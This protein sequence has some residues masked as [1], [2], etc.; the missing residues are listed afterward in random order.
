MFAQYEGFG[1]YIDSPEWQ[2]YVAGLLPRIRANDRT[3][4][5]ADVQAAIQWFKDY[6]MNEQFAKEYSAEM[7]QW[8][9]IYSGDKP[10]PSVSPVPY[11]PIPVPE[12]VS[13]GPDGKPVMIDTFLGLSMWSWWVIGGG[14]ILLGI[15]M[16]MRGKKPVIV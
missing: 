4:N 6:P 8:L 2:K 13:I 11:G 5:V 3:I 7:Q 1:W 16:A 12:P 15:G 9:S 14:V 10:A